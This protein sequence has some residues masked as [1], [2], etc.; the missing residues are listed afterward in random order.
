M[1]G[2]GSDSPSKQASR[3]AEVP[4]GGRKGGSRDL[5]LTVDHELDDKP[6]ASAGAVGRAPV[7]RTGQASVNVAAGEWRR[8]GTDGCA[9]AAHAR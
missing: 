7:L 8:D 2:S 4:G 1:L 3:R 9:R 5:P 6:A